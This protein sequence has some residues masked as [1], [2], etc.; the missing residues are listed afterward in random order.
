M[1]L[2]P[3]LIKNPKY[4]P[5]RKNKGIVPD[6]KDHRVGYVPI[7]CGMCMECMAKKA[8]NWRVRLIEDI[9]EHRNGKFITLTFSNESYT[10]L[11]KEIDNSI[12]GY[13]LDNEIATLAVRRFLERYRKHNGKSIR[14]WL[15]TELGS[16]ETE[17][18]HLHGILYMDDIQDLEKYWQYGYV[19][20]GQ[21]KNGAII[22]YVNERTINYII[23]YC[24]KVDL[25]H[26]HYK[27]KILCSKG[28]GGTYKDRHNA[29]K[30]NKFN[31]K[32]TNQMYKLANGKEVSLPIY[33]RNQLYDEEQREKLWIHKL[34]ENVR[35]VGGEKVDA[36]DDEGYYKLVRHYRKINKQL[37]YG[38]P[39][40]WD[41]VKYENARRQ[42]FQ[43]K[44]FKNRNGK[45]KSFY[46][47]GELE[48]IKEERLKEI[49]ELKRQRNAK[50]NNGNN[51]NMD[52]N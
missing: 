21:E 1:C 35:Y 24:T 39:E 9:K 40:D 26:K 41:A 28:I 25:L 48:R 14:H 43:D 2:F 10:D 12:E 6:L 5:N 19:W 4:R 20:K 18:L 23:K 46:K 3:K 22:N 52:N 17:H 44:R 30:V 42:L 32:D 11:A 38:S 13:E 16:G 29:K 49:E 8:N 33:W 15:I 27:P 31:G 50:N 51:N 47:E 36:D 34:D 37:G 7:G 45:E